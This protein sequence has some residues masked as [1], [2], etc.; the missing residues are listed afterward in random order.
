[1]QNDLGKVKN[2][3]KLR[4]MDFKDKTASNIVMQTMSTMPNDLEF[5]L[6]MNKDGLEPPKLE[7]PK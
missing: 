2:I 4:A 6:N 3:P 5:L 7:Y 1:M